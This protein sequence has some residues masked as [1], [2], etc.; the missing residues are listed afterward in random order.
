ML[1]EALH[2]STVSTFNEFGMR[3]WPLYHRVYVDTLG[4]VESPQMECSHC[5]SFDSDEMWPREISRQV[6]VA[7]RRTLLWHEVRIPSYSVVQIHR[8]VCYH[9]YRRRGLE[10]C[11]L[12]LESGRSQTF[13]EWWGN[14]RRSDKRSQSGD[15][16]LVVHHLPRS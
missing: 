12:I 8:M 3:T 1:R 2:G 4:V 9:E 11:F 6:G 7:S 10:C 16:L 14:E 5:L 15:I 13:K